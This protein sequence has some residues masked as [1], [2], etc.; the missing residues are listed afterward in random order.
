MFCDVLPSVFFQETKDIPVFKPKFVLT[1]SAL[2]H[3]SLAGAKFCVIGLNCELK[4]EGGQKH[5]PELCLMLLRIL[6]VGCFIPGMN[7][8]ICSQ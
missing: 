6:T 5:V 2:K 1:N 4:D 8:D 7:A 3:K